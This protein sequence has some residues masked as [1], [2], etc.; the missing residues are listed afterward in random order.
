MGQTTQ[1]GGHSRFALSYSRDECHVCWRPLLAYAGRL[2]SHGPIKGK[3]Q[4]GQTSAAQDTEG[5]TMNTREGA[6]RKPVAPDS[7]FREGNHGDNGS[8]ATGDPECA[9]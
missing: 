8:M 4:R 1:S 5:R 7:C 3:T 9:A 2:G 6:H